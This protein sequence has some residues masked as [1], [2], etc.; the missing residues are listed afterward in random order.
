MRQDGEIHQAEISP[1]LV[2]VPTQFCI[3]KVLDRY[4]KD[5]K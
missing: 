1:I 3:Y 2:H 5:G 4:I